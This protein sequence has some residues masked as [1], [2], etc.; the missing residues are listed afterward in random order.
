MVPVVRELAAAG[1]LV[2]VDTMRAAVAEQAVA[3]GARLVNDVSG[4]LADPGDD[5]GGRRGRGAVRGHALARP[6][7][8]H[9][10]PGGLRR[11][12]RRGAST[13]CAPAWSA[14]WPA[15][16]PPERIVL[17]PGP[18]LRQ[19]RRPRPGA[20]GP[21]RRELR[22][23]GRP[24]LVAA[25]RKRFLGRVLAGAAGDPP[26]AR[27]RDAATAAVTAIAAREGAWAVRVH[28]VQ[29]E[30]GR[31]TGGPGH[32][33]RAAD[34]R[35]RRHDGA[36]G[37]RVSG[38]GRPTRRRAGQPGVLRRRRDLDALRCTNACW[39]GRWP[40][41][42]PWSTPGWP[43]LRGRGEV[44]RS[45]A[46]IMANTE[47]IQFFLTDVEIAVDGDT[48]LVTCTENILTGG[49]AEEDGSAGSAG[50]RAGG[51]HQRLPAHR[52]GLAAVV[53][54]RLAGAGGP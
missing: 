32:R 20:A 23:L 27:E 22:A 24:L 33:G 15:A 44:M 17:D 48:A 52:R 46:L 47:Y 37:T 51:G 14:R 3:A 9:E 42:S 43:V 53:A 41:R 10:Q 7:H 28:E 34:G 1:V 16:S 31:G 50:R 12:A 25:S 38:S 40:S 26:P 36:D 30:R 11:R 19:E 45:Y 54:P 49:P 29:R 39:P 21:P 4:G 5:P 8:R 18:G 2:S 13:S 6:E 35:R